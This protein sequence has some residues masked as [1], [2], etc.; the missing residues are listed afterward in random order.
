MGTGVESGPLVLTGCG[1]FPR[2]DGDVAV[3]GQRGGEHVRR[4]P[5]VLLLQLR[6][7]PAE[8][9]TR[10]RVWWSCEEGVVVL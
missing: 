1:L 6:Q 7:L 4:E 5:R 2:G 8:G 10:E 9:R 3:A